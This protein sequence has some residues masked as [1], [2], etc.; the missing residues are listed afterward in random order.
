MKNPIE[1]TEFSSL[2]KQCLIL[3]FILI[4][5]LYRH[6]H[7]SENIDEHLPHFYKTWLSLGMWMFSFMIYFS[8]DLDAYYLTTFATFG[9]LLTPYYWFS[10]KAKQRLTKAKWLCFGGLCLIDLV[11]IIYLTAYALHLMSLQLIL[12]MIINYHHFQNKNYHP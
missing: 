12:W 10:T 3:L 5:Y 1:I 2:N 7:I 8:Y 4:I 11:L 9:A 6:Y